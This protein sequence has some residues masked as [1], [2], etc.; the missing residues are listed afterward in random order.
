MKKGT[1]PRLSV[2]L[3]LIML[4]C[5]SAAS[6]SASDASSRAQTEDYSSSGLTVVITPVNGLEL[7]VGGFDNVNADVRGGS[8]SY[9][10]E[11]SL[12]NSNLARISETGSGEY[13]M[14]SGLS[15]GSTTITVRVTDM[16]TNATGTDTIALTVKGS[17]QSAQAAAALTVVITP[18]NNL[19]VY[20]NDGAA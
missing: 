14:L 20:V 12:G 8:G 1:Q 10:Y 5:V 11:W 16:T 6:A 4:L 9:Y 3:T 7:A 19:D 17:G 2:L 15:A 18:A 13:A